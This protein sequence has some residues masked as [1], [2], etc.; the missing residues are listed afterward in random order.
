MTTLST[1]II[2]AAFAARPQAASKWPTHQER[3]EDAKR[4]LLTAIAENKIYNVDYVWAMA[5]VKTAF[6]YAARPIVT[7]YYQQNRNSADLDWSVDNSV[8]M[9]HIAG[10]IKKLA[11]STNPGIQAYVALLQ[12]TL[13][14]AQAFAA[15]KPVIV[16]GRKP[17]EIPVVED[18]T[19]TGTCAICQHRQKLT[20]GQR[21]LVHHGFQISN[22]HGDYL[23]YRN[24]S[25]FGVGHEPYE[26]SCEANKR[27]I[28]A[29]GHA[30]DGKVGYL[31]RLIAGEV[32]ELH[33]LD[34][35][36]DRLIHAY[37]TELVVVK[38][39]EKHFAGML[40]SEI[41]Q[42]EGQIRGIEM[43]I[44]N[45]QSLIDQWQLKPLV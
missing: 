23:G 20:G 30:K 18:L 9:N 34:Q 13:P 7:A 12:E 28:V 35:K 6:E 27:Y 39:G 40:Q 25:C 4:D 1:P 45:H 14:L 31:G 29:L 33:R 22:G 17:S 37:K 8:P 10:K 11:K 42:T 36:Y 2:D 3:F 5:T 32:T 21:K 16:K 19:N 24:G 43:M 44:E 26:L 41:S 15:L 38:Q